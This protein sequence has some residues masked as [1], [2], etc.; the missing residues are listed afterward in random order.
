M[1]ARARHIDS[2]CPAH[3]RDFT[4]MRSSAHPDTLILR[5]K[6]IAIDN[7]DRPVQCYRYECFDLDGTPMGCSIHYSNQEEA[8]VFF[9][10]LT[11]LHTQE[12]STTL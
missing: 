4:I 11:E 12:Y 7:P 3:C 9:E 5:W 10:G 8:N 1:M 6:T 2:N